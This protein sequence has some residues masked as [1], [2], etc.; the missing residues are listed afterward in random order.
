MNN[1]RLNPALQRDSCILGDPCAGLSGCGCGCGGKCG[2]GLFEAGMDFT[3]WG[4]P[5]WTVALI[6]GYALIS[7]WQTTGRAART[8]RAIPGER[9]KARA[10]AYRRRR[11]N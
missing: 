9:R 2:M 6:G 11:R 4:W 5:E 10:A 1:Y 3:S 8:I 7:M